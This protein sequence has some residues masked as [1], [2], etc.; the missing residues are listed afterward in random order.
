MNTNQFYFLKEMWI[1][2]KYYADILGE[3]FNMDG[4]L[5]LRLL[6]NHMSNLDMLINMHSAQLSENDMIKF[7]NQ[8]LKLSSFAIFIED[9]ERIN[10]KYVI[11]SY[12]EMI[13][14]IC[15]HMDWNVS[16]GVLI[17]KKDESQLEALKYGAGGI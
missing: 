16:Q 2:N 13:D 12:H 5:S 11:H 7:M 6:G 15:Y 1:R 14:V 10:K 17:I 3:D 4:Y 8:L 9:D